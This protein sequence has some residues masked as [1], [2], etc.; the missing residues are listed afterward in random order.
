MGGGARLGLRY[1]ALYPLLDRTADGDKGEWS[2]LFADVQLM[3][4]E[5]LKIP[6]K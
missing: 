6:V 1:E 2:H 5:V 3:E 4:L